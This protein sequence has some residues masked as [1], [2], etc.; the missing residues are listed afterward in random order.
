M[1]LPS[2]KR[3]TVDDILGGGS[4]DFNWDDT[5]AA[6]DD[7]DPIPSGVYR[8]LLTNGRL[9]TARTGT[10]S[11]KLEFSVLDGDHAGRKLWH[12]AW[13]TR[14]AKTFTKRDLEKVGFT[15]QKALEHPPRSGYVVDVKV[16]LRT[17]NDG[18]QS[19]KVLGFKVV[20]EAPP[21]GT[22]DADD[23]GNCSRNIDNAEAGSADLDDTP[24]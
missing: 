6:S 5:V 17:E 16:A 18:R 13:F 8:C 4:D 9:S 14:N 24:F 2:D 19:N 15:S 23:E 1:P 11:Y 22:L 10:R 3:Q 7:F 21:P 20:V 12:D